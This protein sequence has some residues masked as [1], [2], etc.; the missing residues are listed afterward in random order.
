MCAMARAWAVGSTIAALT[1][2][3]A[4][5]A[6]AAHSHLTVSTPASVRVGQVLV[7]SGTAKDQRSVAV[8]RLVGGHWRP[9]ATAH[10]AS[11]GSYEIGLR[12]PSKPTQ[13]RLRVGYHWG[14]AVTLLPRS[15]TLMAMPCSV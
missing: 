9:L 15:E 14:K 10:V 13:W 7:V 3:T 5:P 1:L 12:A 4:A 11:G 2:G 8:Q 6:A